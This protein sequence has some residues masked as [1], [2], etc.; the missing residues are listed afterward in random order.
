MYV[1][2][3]QA[4]YWDSM[5]GKKETVFKLIKLIKKEIKETY[6][7]NTKEAWAWVRCMKWELRAGKVTKK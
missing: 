7:L 3:N 4:L 1:E 2:E 5:I 6:F